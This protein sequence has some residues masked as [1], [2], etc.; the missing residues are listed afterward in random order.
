MEKMVEKDYRSKLKLMRC[1]HCGEHKYKRTYYK[2]HCIRWCSV[3]EYPTVW[4]IIREEC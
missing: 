2:K 1:C 4:K 3:C